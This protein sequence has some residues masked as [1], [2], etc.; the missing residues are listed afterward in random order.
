[1]DQSV[2]VATGLKFDRRPL[3]DWQG[4]VRRSTAG[5]RRRLA[6]MTA[7]HH[8]VRNFAVRTLPEVQRPLPVDEIAGKLSLPV[9][10]VRQILEELE[11]HLFFLVRNDGGEVAWAFPVTA[12][13]TPHEMECSRGYLTFGACAEDAFATAFVLG[14][15]IGRRLRIDIR[16]VC[17]Q[18]GRP[19]RLS[20]ASDLMWRV[21]TKG[22]EPLLFVP[23]VN[24]E[25]FRGP[26][27]IDDY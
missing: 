24:W 27:I 15:L 18:S 9:A 4:A 19:L 10:R 22:A 3:A 13:P 6:F 1:M 2:L 8:A 17:A 7:D 21:T 25:G 14:R 23:S 20:V 16:S 12:D 26:N 11:R 5:M